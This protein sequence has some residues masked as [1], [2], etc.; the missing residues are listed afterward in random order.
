VSDLPL[1]LSI[2][3]LRFADRVTRDARTLIEWCPAD[4]VRGVV[5]DGTLP[6]LRARELDRSAR[7]DLAA[8]LRRLGLSLGGVD[9]WIP[10][11]HFAQGAFVDRAVAATLGASELAGDIA[12]LLGQ[13]RASASVKV[14]LPEE[15][16]PDAARGLSG[17]AGAMI[18][19]HRARS[20]QDRRKGVD[21][22]SVL[23]SGGD[24]S[25]ALLA[26][27]GRGPLARLSDAGS[28]G[29]CTVG[30]GR[31]RIA[32]YAMAAAAAGADRVT[33]DLRGLDDAESARTQALA[34]WRGA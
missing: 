3:G 13:P 18:V 4:G 26:L 32:D 25:A 6:S 1:H 28:V 10:A 7:R 20:P 19:D 29:R 27:A 24:P 17:E 8:L 33:L 11:E 23:V 15:L 22:A 5:L 16:H 9:L 31:L 30:M 34:A 14:E 21:P 12:D 2:A